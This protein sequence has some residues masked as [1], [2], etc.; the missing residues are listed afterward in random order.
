MGEVSFE[1]CGQSECVTERDNSL[2]GSDAGLRA[3]W[4][5]LSIAQGRGCVKP[6]FLLTPTRNGYILRLEKVPTR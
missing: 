6:E 5:R 3:P 2:R 4:S 1:A